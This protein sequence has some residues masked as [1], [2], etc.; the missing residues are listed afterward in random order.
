MLFLIYINDINNEIT[1][2]ITLFADDCVPYRNIRNQ[3]DQVILQDD[4]DTISSWAEK[5]VMEQ[6]INTCSVFP[7]A[8]KHISSFHD[9]D[10]HG[11]MLKRITNK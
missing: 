6:H 10:T 4:Q 9:Y 8:L 2:Q 11:I 7:I 3:D 1:S 5:W